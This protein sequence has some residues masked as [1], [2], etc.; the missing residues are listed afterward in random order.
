MT[1]LYLPCCCFLK[2]AAGVH[3]KNILSCIRSWLYL[4]L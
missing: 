4:L 2:A 3:I 1:A